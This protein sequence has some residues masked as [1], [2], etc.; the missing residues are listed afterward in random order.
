MMMPDWLHQRARL[1]PDH[2]AI[3]TDDRTYTFAQ[4]DRAVKRAADTLRSMG[5]RPGDHVATL[6]TNS[7]AFVIAVHA[8][9]GC[10][11]VMVP[12]N[13]RL[14]PT[15]LRWQIDDSDTRWL[16]YEHERADVVTQLDLNIPACEIECLV[17]PDCSQ[18]KYDA[19]LDGET[20]RVD[21]EAVQGIIYTSGTTGN[22]KGAMLTLGNHWWNAVGS[23][24]N[25]GIHHDDRWLAMLPLFHVGGLAILF[26]SV[27][28]GHPV[29]IHRRFDPA[30]A[31][32]AIDHQG[33]TIA[34]VVSTMLRAIIDERQ[35][36]PFPKS[37][38]ALLTGGGPIDPALLA[39]CAKIG[40]PVIQ[41]YGMTE[42]ASQ[43]ATLSPADALRKPGSAGKPLFP[44]EIRV[45]KP[46]GEI[47]EIEV[48]G[49]SVSPGYYNRPED[50]QTRTDD[51]WFQTGDL[52]RF[53]EE[54][55]LYVVDRRSDLIIS[56]GENVYPKEVE[57]VLTRH[58]AVLEAA[59]VGVPHAKWGQVPIAYVVFRPDR[60]TDEE[61]G[62]A[63][64]IEHCRQHLARYKVPTQIIPVESLPRNAT[65]KLLRRGLV[66]A[67][68]PPLHYIDTAPESTQT[69]YLLIHG[70]FSTGRGTWRN[71]LDLP[72]VRFVAID[73]RGNGSSPPAAVS[74]TIESDADDVWDVA[75]R[76]GAESVHLVGH[77][78]GALIALQAAIDAPQRM[79]SLHLIEPPYLS[80][81][82]DDPDVRE[83]AKQTQALASAVP[84]LPAEAL[85]E[86]FFGMLMGAD[87]VR[88]I[89]EKPVWPSLVQEAERFQRQQFVGDYP[90]ERVTRLLERRKGYDYPILLYTGGKSHPALIKITRELARLI[91]HARL[92][93][94]DE[95]GHNVQ[96]SGDQFNE[97]LISVSS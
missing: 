75:D 18:S 60:R 27:I 79:R 26:R 15:E 8:L 6:A 59:V 83:L 43:A 17:S 47:G 90:P 21:L 93:E 94:F 37:L 67:S 78:Y 61:R 38:R 73:R 88:A 86:R 13:V 81:L 96:H 48:R 91:D 53:D 25:L 36:Q 23:A 77:S 5:I 14:T 74:T 10:R 80:L 92:F 50:N 70:D 28:Y 30:K 44:N 20:P 95:A 19:K 31:N 54:G 11:A 40:A 3:I 33:V 49:P 16:L 76:I 39:T 85:T 22:P 34:S 35:K 69:P 9:I 46:I 41:T 71:Q 65:G 42:T 2:D 84:A 68:R 82:P 58:P 7:D 56:G 24:L 72:D 66:P 12:L 55:F 1:S 52:G 64:I 97:I 51:G 87:A 63:D 32:D 45:N 4:L 29:I 89:K 62:I 57:D